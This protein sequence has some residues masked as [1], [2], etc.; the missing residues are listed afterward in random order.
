MTLMDGLNDSQKQIAQLAAL[1]LNN[2]AIAA[3]VYLSVKTVK[4]HLT[5]IYRAYQVRDRIEL[6]LKLAGEKA[7]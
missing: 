4:N 6:M 1:G 5:V 7:S 3:Q 2:K